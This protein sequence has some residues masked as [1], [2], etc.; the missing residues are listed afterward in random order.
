MI[1]HSPALLLLLSKWTVSTLLLAPVGKA[2]GQRQDGLTVI[3]NAGSGRRL[4]AHYGAI[5]ESGFGAA[6]PEGHVWKEQWW[7]FVETSCGQDLPHAPT[8]GLPCYEI[9]NNDSGRNIYAEAGKNWQKGVGAKVGNNR[10]RRNEK[11]FFVESDCGPNEEKCYFIV[12]AYSGRRLYASRRKTWEEGVG[13]VV[14]GAQV[15]EDQKWFID[16]PVNDGDSEACLDFESLNF[17][18][19]TIS[20]IRSTIEDALDA[21]DET[22]PN[23]VDEEIVYLTHLKD[24]SEAEYKLVNMCKGLGSCIDVWDDITIDGCTYDAVVNKV[25]KVLPFHCEHDAETELQFFTS[26]E[27]R[28]EMQQK[29]HD[30]CSEG[31]SNVDTSTFANVNAEFDDE[32]MN[33]YV[34]GDTFL[35]GKASRPSA[36]TF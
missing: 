23:G 4:Y 2:F 26:S 22:C 18:D 9:V 25:D 6:G 35:N 34:A 12:N 24:L 29:I 10:E 31:W 27:T 36:I 32:F 15:W 17:H 16:I 7:K 28:A 33:S 5:D 8:N 30:M 19:C 3:T 1:L 21:L 11:W 20:N 14:N 13:A